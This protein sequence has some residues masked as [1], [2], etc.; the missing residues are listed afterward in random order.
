MRRNLIGGLALVLALATPAA[1]QRP[2]DPFRTVDPIALP[3][4]RHEVLPAVGTGGL[5]HLPG[6]GVERLVEAIDARC[7]AHQAF[8]PASGS[9]AR[10]RSSATP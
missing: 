5:G 6:Q 7:A 1:A 4:D 3:L 9:D 8:S 2:Y 10:V